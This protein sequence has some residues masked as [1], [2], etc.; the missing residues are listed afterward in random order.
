MRAS[1]LI[2][3]TCL[4][5]GCGGSSSGPSSP[6]SASPVLEGRTTNVI[7][8][9]GTPA[10]V[11]AATRA[12]Q[13]DSDGTFRL[14]L[15]HSGE[16]V[17]GVSARGFVDRETVTRTGVGAAQQQLSL[18]SEQFDLQAFNEICR[19]SNSRLQRWTSKPALVILTSVMTYDGP[20]ET[21]YVATGERLTDA[22]VDAMVQDFTR[23]L[24][25]LSGHTWNAFDTI[26]REA[27]DDGARASVQRNGM[28]VVG[29]YR[30]IVSWSNTIGLG[31]W[32]DQPDGTVTAGT[33][34]LDYAFDKTDDRRWLLRM[35]EFGH[36]LGYTHVT[37]RLSLMNPTI[38]PE[39]TTFDT[40]SATI[41]Y[42]RPPGNRAP[43]V[44][45]TGGARPSGFLSSE[46]G[47]R[48]APPI[49]CGPPPR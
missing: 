46:G 28:V 20:S 19:T 16:Y 5:A 7:G 8:G 49:I 39:P 11:R 1:P 34:L 23:A 48:W 47:G 24:Q 2:L 21:S 35:H 4:L 30:G 43:D 18:I 9:A 40:Q 31:R 42:Q 13:T 6:S 44:D 17:T 32:Q 45:P 33:V 22:E 10:T 14:E 37:S 36:A 27:V 26:V 12:V 38:G 29:R 25:L 41:A 15:E 3:S